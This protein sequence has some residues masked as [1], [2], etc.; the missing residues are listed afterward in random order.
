[1]GLC[2]QNRTKNIEY[3]LIFLREREINMNKE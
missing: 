2:K 3:I 1:M